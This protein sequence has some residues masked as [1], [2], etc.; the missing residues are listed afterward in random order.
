[1]VFE[2][3]VMDYIDSLPDGLFDLPQGAGPLKY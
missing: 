3:D 1:V 2:K